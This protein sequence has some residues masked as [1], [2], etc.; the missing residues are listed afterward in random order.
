MTCSNTAGM[1][2][3]DVALIPVAGTNARKRRNEWVKAMSLFFQYV[4]GLHV[5]RFGDEFPFWSSALTGTFFT[6]SAHLPWQYGG[7]SNLRPYLKR[8]AFRD[9][10][11]WL[12][13]HAG[14]VGG[15][16]LAAE[17]D[18]ELN[19]RAV[20]TIDCPIRRDLDDVWIAAREHIRYHEH[21]YASGLGMRWFGQ[22]GR[23][24]QQMSWADRNTKVKGWHSGSLR[25][26]KHFHQL[27]AV[28]ERVRATPD[29]E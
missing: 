3:L 27:D 10:I 7:V 21:L 25:K 12:H 24:V 15:Y 16:A 1:R 2:T 17:D 23:F 22:R 29:V 18:E 20:V 5:V 13:S 19:V 4:G 26:P 9:R 6:F 11:L 28:I 14:A 8:L